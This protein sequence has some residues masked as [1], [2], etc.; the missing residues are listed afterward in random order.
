MSVHVGKNQTL[1]LSH[2]RLVSELLAHPNLSTQRGAYSVTCLSIA[3]RSFAVVW[4]GYFNSS[5]AQGGRSCS[6]LEFAAATL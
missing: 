2:S 3:T 6:S 1:T 4:V 5:E